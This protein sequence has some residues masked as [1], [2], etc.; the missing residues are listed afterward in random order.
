[1]KRIIL[2]ESQY[3]RLVS[4]PLNEQEI[5][6]GDGYSWGDMKNVNIINN[7]LLLK[8]SLWYNYKQNLYIKSIDEDKV[9]I[10][11]EKYDEEVK[12]Y[13]KKKMKM[14]LIISD[15]PGDSIDDEGNVDFSFDTEPV[16]D[17]EQYDDVYTTEDDFKVDSEFGSSNL[18]NKE[19]IILHLISEKEAVSHSYDSANPGKI[20]P[21]LSK[22]TMEQAKIKNGSS[23]IG[24]YQFMPENLNRFVTSA[25]LKMSDKFSP[26]NQDKM[27]LAIL[28]G[29]MD[30][31]DELHN[32]LV[33]TWAALPLLYDREITYKKKVY[34]RKRGDSYYEGISGNKAGLTPEHFE[35]ALSSCGCNMTKLNKK[36]EIKINGESDVKDSGMLRILIIGDSQSAGSGKYHSKLN[37]KKYSVK[38]NSKTSRF[39]SDMLK[40][41]KNETLSN[42]DVIIIMGGGN[43]SNQK[44]TSTAAQNNLDNM[45]GY[46][47]NKSDAVLITISNPTKKY[48]TDWEKIYPS[49]DKI[50]EYTNGN[51]I[52]DYKINSNSLGEDNFSKDKIH[53]NGKGHNWIYEKLKNILDNL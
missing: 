6:F 28:K 49:N 4:Q 44:T 3:K 40:E 42:Y 16:E 20:I 12:E 51:T 38:N 13:I 26:K 7:L 14:F 37:N 21:G 34:K 23:A 46:V 8:D 19:K 29:K 30:D 25:G 35:S 2:T 24:R 1:M 10:N 15:N 22:L 32:K 45:Y 33:S 48:F 36:L 53:L 27:A 41:L 18:T 5:I 43:D 17:E 39:T 11:L 47:K 9:I 50:A 31:C 52:S